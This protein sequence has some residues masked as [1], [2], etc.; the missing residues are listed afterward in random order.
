MC[1][2][3][4]QRPGSVSNSRTGI[5]PG[6]SCLRASPTW[7]DCAAAQRSLGCSYRIQWLRC[8]E[9]HRMKKPAGGSRVATSCMST[10]GRYAETM[11]TLGAVQRR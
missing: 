5:K 9:S 2:K 7:Q 6:E 1:N 4:L 8:G 3:S 10:A 11:S